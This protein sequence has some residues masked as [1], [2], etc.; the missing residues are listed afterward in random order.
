M[1]SKSIATLMIPRRPD[2]LWSRNRN[3]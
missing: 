1:R 2:R 3:R